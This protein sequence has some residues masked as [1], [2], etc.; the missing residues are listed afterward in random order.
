MAGSLPS[1]RW[2]SPEA[3]CGTK[4]D[5]RSDVYSLGIVMWELVTCDCPFEE[6]SPDKNFFAIKDAII[7]QGLRPSIPAECPPGLASL[8]QHCWQGKPEDRP[9]LDLIVEQLS[10]LLG[11][12]VGADLN[13]SSNLAI[14]DEIL[15]NSTPSRY[16]V[17]S[18]RQTS[19]LTLLQ[20]IKTPMSI[21]IC[22]ALLESSGT[23]VVGFKSG[24]VSFH[25]HYVRKSFFTF[26]FFHRKLIFFHDIVFFIG[27]SR[28]LA[29]EL[30]CAVSYWTNFG[31]VSC[32][33]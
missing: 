5:E 27:E 28:Y 4:F 24:L 32:W 31:V 22:L 33:E 9:S 20:T 18:P 30:S 3:I 2:A 17:Q 25:T 10:V 23:V 1:W 6:F 12:P 11:V 13:R 29:R 7:E 8:I 15:P 14:S 19:A 26:Y 16:T 21:P